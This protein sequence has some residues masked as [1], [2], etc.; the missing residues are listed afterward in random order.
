[1]ELKYFDAK[2][3][4]FQDQAQFT[5]KHTAAT[6]SFS[7]SSLHIVSWISSECLRPINKEIRSFILQSGK[8]MKST[9][10]K[11]SNTFLKSNH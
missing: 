4:V 3:L 5:C 6:T 2:K 9:Y 1:M 7:C 8:S 10:A 11:F